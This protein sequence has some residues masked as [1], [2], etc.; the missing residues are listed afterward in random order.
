MAGNVKRPSLKDIKFD[1]ST[2]KLIKEFSL[3]AK[4]D[5]KLLSA[6]SSLFIQNNFKIPEI[7]YLC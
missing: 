1:L 3:Q 6:I 7:F 2:I 5:N 4:G